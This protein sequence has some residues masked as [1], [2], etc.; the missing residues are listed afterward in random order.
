PG[1]HPPSLRG[2]P[3]IFTVTDS[4]G[5]SSSPATT[6]ATVANVAPSVNAGANQTVTVGT[7]VTLSASFTD[8]GV[9]DAPWT[10]AIAWGDG[11]AA[12]TGGTRSEAQA[13]T[14]T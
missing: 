13:S 2:A 11:A 10:Y 14:A 5:A 4:H 8:P 9:N 3:P 12:T 1:H 7:S 6:T